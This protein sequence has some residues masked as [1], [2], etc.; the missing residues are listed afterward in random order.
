[1]SPVRL[2]EARV[3]QLERQLTDTDRAVVT[4]LDQVRLATSRQLQRLHVMDGSPGSNLRRTQS[5][6]TKLSRRRI[7]ARLDRQV[8]GPRAGS[9]GYVYGLDVAGQRL[10][11][12]CGPAGGIRIRRPW[13]PGTSFVDHTLAVT[14]LYVRLREAA[15]SGSLELMAFEAEP[16][17][18]RGFS[19]LGG[20]RVTLKPDAFVRVARGDFEVLAFIEVDRATQSGPAIARK[21]R[22]YRRYFDT[23]REQHR[24]GVFPRVLFLAPSAARK[25]ALVDLAAAQPADSWP[26]FGIRAFEE[27]VA[28]LAQEVS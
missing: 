23:G 1:M 24:H 27:A 11:S 2:T 3:V 16:L 28:A 6:L 19:G 18:W 25:A 17:C 22:T 7:L 15:A 4:T 26:L 10:A 8:G 14:E 20:G 12:A 13:T 9:A 21:L 5:V